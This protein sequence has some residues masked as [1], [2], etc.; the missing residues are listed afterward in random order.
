MSKQEE[1]HEWY[2]SYYEKKGKDRNSIRNPEVLFQTLAMTAAFI[3][4]TYKIAHKPE[5]ALVLD[6][7][8]GGGGATF[9]SF[10]GAATS[11]KTLQELTSCRIESLKPG[12]FIHI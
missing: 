11:L 6:V 8:C 7:G 9:I 1:T 12:R 4:A 10:F 5:K 2:R 3:R